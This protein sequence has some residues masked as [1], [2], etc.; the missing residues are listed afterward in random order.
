[1]FITC[2][3]PLDNFSCVDYV[4]NYLLNVENLVE[5]IYRFF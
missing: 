1:M 4:E 3:N 2:G 5:N